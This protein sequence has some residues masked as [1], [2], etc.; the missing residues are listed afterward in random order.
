MF[1]L[2]LVEGVDLFGHLQACKCDRQLPRMKSFNNCH[3]RVIL[4]SLTTI[5]I[6][7]NFA[8][9]VSIFAIA[10]LGVV[11]LFW[12]NICGFAAIMECEEY[13]Y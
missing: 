9:L 12:P 3:G 8:Q 2:C 5:C 11:I 4:T 6:R 13:E 1:S 10:R 7:K